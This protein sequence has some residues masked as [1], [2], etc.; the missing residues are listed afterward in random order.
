MNSK[1][2]RET[3]LTLFDDVLVHCSIGEYARV[4][5]DSEYCL[6]IRKKYMPKTLTMVHVH[7]DGCLKMSESGAVNDR[8]MVQ[9][10]SMA[11]GIP[12]IFV[13][14]SLHGKAGKKHLWAFTKYVV[15]LENNKPTIYETL[16]FTDY[17]SDVI[18]GA[19]KLLAFSSRD[20]LFNN[21]FYK[22][23]KTKIGKKVEIS[24]LLL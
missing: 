23:L 3:S 10:W 22:M 8:N 17:D 5:F 24:K 12:I 7:P 6:G 19:L 4:N 1:F 11:F 20:S 16:S 15:K 18:A 14:I 9:G 21:F 2:I 13:I